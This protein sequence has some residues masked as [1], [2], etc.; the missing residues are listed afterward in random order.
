MRNIVAVLIPIAFLV[1]MAGCQQGSASGEENIQKPDL[2][3]DTFPEAQAE[4]QE[5]IDETFQSLIDRDA[6]KLISFHAYGPKFTHFKDGLPREG[7][8]ANEKGERDL[9]AA[10]SDW[11]YDTNDLKINVFGEVAVVTYHADFRPTIAGEIKQLHYQTTIVL[12]NTEQGWKITH[13]HFSPL[14]EG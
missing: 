6:D 10:I 12:V 11:E 7:S 1:A 9:V 5:V 13:E 8:E 3:N 2:I 14:I 4:I